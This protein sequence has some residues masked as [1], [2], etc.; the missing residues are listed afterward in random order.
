MWI[1]SHCH[2]D[3][4]VFDNGR[5]QLME[6]T[7]KLGIE[8][9]LVPGVEAQHW[10][11]ILVLCDA[12]P[13]TVVPAWGL[14]PCF[15]DHHTLDDLQQLD[16]WLHRKR[17]VAVGEIGLDF[18]MDGY[19]EEKQRLYFREQIKLARSHKLPIVVHCRKAHDQCLKLIRELGFAEGG[20]MH[21]FSGSLQQ[22]QRCLDAGFKLGI[23]GAATYERATRLQQL[24][25][26]L[27]LDSFV[28]ETDAPDIPPCFA[29]DEPNTP[30]NLPRIA[31]II[32]ERAGIDPEQ[33]ARVTTDNV[34]TLLK[35]PAS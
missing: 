34:R 22:A 29:R 25:V 28:L 19:D 13:D 7:V 3:F 12:W 10:Q 33:F 8:K 11:R 15:V 4:A 18:F 23:G 31:G 26:R 5:T 14:H 6:Q 1:D 17:P 30:L 35:L 27:P 21:A 20:F 2:L 32:C 16:D 24:I 9:I